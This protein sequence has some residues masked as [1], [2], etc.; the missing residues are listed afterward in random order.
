MHKGGC[1]LSCREVASLAV[2]GY[3]VA[4]QRLTL[5]IV[6]VPPVVV[7]LPIAYAST[8]FASTGSLAWR[9]DSDAIAPEP[10]LEGQT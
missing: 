4:E 9:L 10:E 2:S 6:V 1:I 7:S 5:S 8:G 3:L